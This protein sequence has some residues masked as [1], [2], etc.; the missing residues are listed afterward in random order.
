M[1]ELDGGFGHPRF[2][3]DQRP[4]YFRGKMADFRQDPGRKSFVFAGVS[5]SLLM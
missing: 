2:A 3:D 5:W 1:A 4:V